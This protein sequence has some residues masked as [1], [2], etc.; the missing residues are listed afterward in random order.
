MVVCSGLLPDMKISFCVPTLPKPRGLETRKF[1]SVIYSV[2][3]V[4]W[5]TSEA[6]KVQNI[7]YI[8]RINIGML[9]ITLK[10]RSSIRISAQC[11]AV[12]AIH[13][14]TWRWTGSN[15]HL[16]QRNLHFK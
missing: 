2:C 10:Y 11:S 7:V 13:V 12:Q 3:Y 5:C 16:Q 1:F 8:L 4:F 14:E 6:Y 9:V 15:V